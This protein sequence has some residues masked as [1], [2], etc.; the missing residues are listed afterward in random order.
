MNGIATTLT[1]WSGLIRRAAPPRA[2]V[3]RLNRGSTLGQPDDA[4]QQRRVLGSTLALLAQDAP[5]PLLRLDEKAE[6][7]G[8]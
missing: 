8:R 7:F 6:S 2:T 1:S 5:V 3:T 4:A